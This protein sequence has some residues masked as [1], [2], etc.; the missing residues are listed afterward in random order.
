MFSLDKGQGTTKGAYIDT[1]KQDFSC[2]QNCNIINFVNNAPDLPQNCA[3]IFQ[4]RPAGS[5]QC[6]GDFLSDL[7]RSCL[8]R[9]RLKQRGEYGGALSKTTSC[10]LLPTLFMEWGQFN[11]VACATEPV[12]PLFCS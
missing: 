9:V 10:M 4:H 2:G 12:E 8:F 7:H 11:V 5:D 1:H 3:A 6:V